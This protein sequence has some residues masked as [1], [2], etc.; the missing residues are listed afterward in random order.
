MDTSIDL[1]CWCGRKNW[2]KFCKGHR[3]VTC[4]WAPLRSAYPQLARV[5][6]SGLT[7]ARG[8]VARLLHRGVTRDL[9]HARMVWVGAADTCAA[10]FGHVCARRLGRFLLDALCPAFYDTPHIRDG[11]MQRTSSGLVLHAILPLW[12]LLPLSRHAAFIA[13]TAYKV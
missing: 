9:A 12:L 3:P 5:S 11:G 2:G 6:V 4:L 13:C 7:L 1:L 8:G 10:F